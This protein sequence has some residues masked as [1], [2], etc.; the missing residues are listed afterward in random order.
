MAAGGGRKRSLRTLHHTVRKCKISYVDC[1]VFLPENEHA[2]SV[3][4]SVTARD[5]RR[6]SRV[7][8]GPRGRRGD[9]T[10]TLSPFFAHRYHQLSP[11]VEQ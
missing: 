11:S 3:G 9:G 4:R 6:V 10:T 2:P 8:S 7:S 5:G 1:S